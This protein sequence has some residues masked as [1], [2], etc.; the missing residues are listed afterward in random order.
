VM[1]AIRGWSLAQI[2]LSKIVKDK[3]NTCTHT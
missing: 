2:R 1:V 3:T